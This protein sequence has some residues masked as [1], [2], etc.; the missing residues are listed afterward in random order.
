MQFYQLA[1]GARFEFRGREYVK[2]AMSMTQDSDG[3]GNI[4]QAGAEVTPIGEPLLL[5]EAEAAKWKPSEIPWTAHLTP[6]PGQ[7]R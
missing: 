3:I 1:I 7:R 2:K 5:S 4:F 6:A